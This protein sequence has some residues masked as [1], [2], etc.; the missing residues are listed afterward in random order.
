M[1]T[2]YATRV[3]SGKAAIPGKDFNLSVSA[4]T[5]FKQSKVAYYERYLVSNKATNKV[6]Q[7]PAMAWGG[8]VDRLLKAK[9]REIH[10]AG[11]WEEGGDGVDDPV[12][13][14][15]Y[16]LEDN[17][18]RTLGFVTSTNEWQRIEDVVQDQSKY[19]ISEAKVSGTIGGIKWA[20]RP[21]LWVEGWGGLDW[22]F[23]QWLT[24][25]G[26]WKR[27]SDATAG[28][29]KPGHVGYVGRSLNKGSQDWAMQGYLYGELCKANIGTLE[30]TGHTVHYVWPG[31]LVEYKYNPTELALAGEE[32]IRLGTEIVT[33]CESGYLTC[34]SLQHQLDIEANGVGGLSRFL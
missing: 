5:C 26:K 3:K 25:D 1:S 18:P 28:H 20:G 15:Q 13:M 23:G 8:M 11:L 7:T 9:L 14:A 17:I 24:S 19:V 6:V 29:I 2:D 16:R 21:D 10:R 34:M 4:A 12:G 31:G 33:A 32:L 30:S 22:K 27:I